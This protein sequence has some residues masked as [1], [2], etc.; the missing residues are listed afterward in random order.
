MHNPFDRL[1]RSN[2]ALADERDQLRDM[3]ATLEQESRQM[4]ARNERLEKENIE[5][6]SMVLAQARTIRKFQ[7]KQDDLK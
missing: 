5:L 1:Q 6:Y 7:N 4:R 3:I 2:L